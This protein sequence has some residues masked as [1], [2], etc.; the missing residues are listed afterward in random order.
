LNPRAEAVIMNY[1]SGFGSLLFEEIVYKKVM[2][3]EKYKNTQFFSFLFLYLL[4][5]KEKC[6]TRF[7]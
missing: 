7:S 5:N 4:K 6:M 2:V 1:G 3:T